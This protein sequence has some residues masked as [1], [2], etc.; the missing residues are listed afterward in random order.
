MIT[1]CIEP[2][3]PTIFERIAGSFVSQLPL[4]QVPLEWTKLQYSLWIENVKRHYAVGDLVT[5][6]QIPFQVDH[7]PEYWIVSYINE[8]HRDVVFDVEIRQPSAITLR[9]PN[10][11]LVRKCPAV[12]RQLTAKEIELVNLLNMPISGTC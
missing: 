9:N 8:C 3:K 4:G 10:G 5:L 11:Q 6:W 2:K 7:A 1:Y 12:L